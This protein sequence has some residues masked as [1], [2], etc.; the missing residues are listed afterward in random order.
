MDT[1]TQAIVEKALRE[2]GVPPENIN[3]TPDEVTPPITFPPRPGVVYQPP[4]A[5]EGVEG[6]KEAT[7]TKVEEPTEKPLTRAEIVQILDE[8]SRRFQSITDRR[9]AQLQGQ[10]GTA[11]QQLQQAQ[12]AR[13][14]EGMPIEDQLKVRLDRME[15]QLGQFG[16]PAPQQ[17]LLSY[18]DVVGYV[19]SFG[20][21]Q[22]DP[23][24]DW[25]AEEDN[26]N[27]GLKRLQT[28]IA[29]AVKEDNEKAVKASK[30]EA[31]KAIAKLRKDLGVD[32]VPT[33]GASGA[34]IPNLDKLS[35]MEK[36]ELGFRLKKEEQ[37]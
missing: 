32:K 35:P 25:A 8:H 24:L 5:E 28:S 4:K 17:Q 13:A 2:A 26:P 22:D 21:K 6:K 29:K 20:L 1:G 15:K 36:I 16:Q 12:E 10:L 18:E 30:D 9:V 34:G 33:S 27:A 14:L 23:R 31:Q 3:L 7:P 11:L 37:G 19:Q